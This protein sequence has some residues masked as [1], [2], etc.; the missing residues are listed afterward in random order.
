MRIIQSKNPRPLNLLAVGPGGLVATA[1]STFGVPGDV[2]VWDIASDIVRSPRLRG[3]REVTALAFHLVDGFLYVGGPRTVHV[4]DVTN[5]LN[6]VADY[7]VGF[8][9][10]AVS[11]NR[12]HLLVAG[13]IHEDG[14]I[15]CLERNGPLFHRV[16]SVKIDPFFR[17]G[18]PTFNQ[19]GSRVAASTHTGAGD[20]VKI[21][22]QVRDA[23]TG[24]VFVSI[25]LDAASPVKQLAF[26]ADGSKLLVR[27]DDR[28][29]QLFDATTG[30][31]AGE[32]VHP[33]RPFVSGIAVHPR[34]P[35]ACARTN[36]TVTF[37]DADARQQLRTL[38]W[39]AGRLVSV[40]FSPDGA[41]AAAGTEDG[42]IVVW[43]V[44]V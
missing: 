20:R 16:W 3:E 18:T 14:D 42:K 30:A 23:V 12:M 40:A 8:A 27:T 6:E 41:L 43:D 11:P 24:Q 10:V 25:P 28:K 31:A 26:T 35:V 13:G 17:Y 7:P 21:T 33:G 1:S 39:K 34:G 2:E 9:A 32:L 15:T 5:A 37:W 36:G 29:V 38:D 19:D 4:F 22:A 44:D